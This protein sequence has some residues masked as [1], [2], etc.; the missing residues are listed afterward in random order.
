MD[1]YPLRN[2]LR[3]LVP[4]GLVPKGW[5]SHY[6]SHG[7]WGG[8]GIEPFHCCIDII[9]NRSFSHAIYSFPIFRIKS[10]NLVI[11]PCSTSNPS[12]WPSSFVFHILMMIISSIGPYSDTLT[13]CHTQPELRLIPTDLNESFAWAGIEYKLSRTLW[14]YPVASFIPKHL[15]NYMYTEPVRCNHLGLELPG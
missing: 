6:Q 10:L 8:M 7:I 11:H 12:L 4:K 3:S 9:M 15:T 14:F 5:M 2:E 1:M 13:H